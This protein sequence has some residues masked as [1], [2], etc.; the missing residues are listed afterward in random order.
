MGR[1]DKETWRHSNVW[2]VQIPFCLWFSRVKDQGWEQAHRLGAGDALKVPSHPQ[3]EEGFYVISK[4]KATVGHLGLISSPSYISH[5]TYEV[6]QLKKSIGSVSAALLCQEP[7]KTGVASKLLNL[8][9]KSEN[10]RVNEHQSWRNLSQTQ[11]GSSF[12][13]AFSGKFLINYFLNIE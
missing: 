1:R 6:Q 11:R 3:L 12:W 8:S 7:S 5:W 10:S 4:C 13:K 9:S 2:H